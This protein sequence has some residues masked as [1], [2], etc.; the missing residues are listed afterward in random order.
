MYSFLEDFGKNCSNKIRRVKWS[1][2]G[3]S[4]PDE[5]PN[6]EHWE[7]SRINWLEF[8]GQSTRE[9]DAA[10]REFWRP[11]EGS[12]LKYLTKNWSTHAYEETA[13]G[14]GKSH[15]KRWEGTIPSAHKGAVIVSVPK[16]QTGKIS[17]CMGAL[18]VVCR[19][20]LPHKWRKLFLRLNKP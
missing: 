13:Q 5:V 14:Q 2:K 20:V 9:E 3:R 17:W 18:S 16:S 8:T 19:N 10:Q 7:S 15:L 6:S 11:L 4:E 1:M 12:P